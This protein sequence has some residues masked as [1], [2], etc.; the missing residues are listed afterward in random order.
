MHSSATSQCD[1]HLLVILM[2]MRDLW[3]TV[4][5]RVTGFTIS[6][7]S[8]DVALIGMYVFIIYLF[9]TICFYTATR[10]RT[11]FRHV[12]VVHDGNYSET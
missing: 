6:S 11:P 8:H 12:E 7:G 10:L 5:M 9:E 4:S 1:Q 3:I 2:R